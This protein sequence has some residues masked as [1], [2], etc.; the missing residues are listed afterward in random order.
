MSTIKIKVELDPDKNNMLGRQCTRI[1]CRKLFKIHVEDHNKFRNAELF[2]PYCGVKE[3]GN[4]MHTDEQ[5]DYIKSIVQKWGAE[6]LNKTFKAIAQ[7]SRPTDIIKISYNPIIVRLKKYVEEEME[8]TIR[9]ENCDRDYSMYSTPLF[10]PFCGPRGP[11]AI[12]N[13]NIE[14]AKTLANPDKI[15]P[16]DVRD[17]LEKNGQVDKLAEGSLIMMIAA[18][19][20]YC[21]SKYLAKVADA[22]SESKTRLSKKIKNLFQNLTKAD[23]LFS[24]F[25]IDIKNVLGPKFSFVQECFEKRHVFV[26]NS[27]I[28][29]QR[30]IEN[31]KAD[32][33]LL[34][35]RVIF[36]KNEVE[37]LANELQKIVLEIEN[38]LK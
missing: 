37:T 5:R 18:F 26:H 1:E 34:D 15:L 28:I 33:S 10:C 24:E 27:G 8:R 3:Y 25:N 9:C 7:K 23:A 2:C 16:Q 29:D 38:K 17:N 14:L 21:K 12:Y 11:L 4:N 35:K 20:T 32:Q 19:E 36:H 30:F 22:S 31:T 13:Q 6:Q